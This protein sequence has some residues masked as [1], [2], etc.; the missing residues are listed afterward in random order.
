VDDVNTG[1]LRRA[2]EADQRPPEIR[3][4]MR[5]LCNV[6][7]ADWQ[8]TRIL[9]TERDDLERLSQRQQR[10]RQAPDVSSDTSRW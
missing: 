8:P 4:R 10:P 1:A 7:H 6:T 3:R 9:A 2:R 5:R